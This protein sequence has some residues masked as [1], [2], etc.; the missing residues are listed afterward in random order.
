MTQSDGPRTT[1]SQPTNQ[2]IRAVAQSANWWTLEKKW[3]GQNKESA[4]KRREGNSSKE[5]TR[6]GKKKRLLCFSVW[7]I[8]GRGNKVKARNTTREDDR[9]KIYLSVSIAL[10]LSLW[11]G[12]H[13]TQGPP[14]TG[15][16]FLVRD[17]CHRSMYVFFFVSAAAVDSFIW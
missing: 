5:S 1:A 14:S 9:H 12:E 16:Y 4:A 11:C 6:K 8:L 3:K 10:S 15:F 13:Y 2:P 7:K 17:Q